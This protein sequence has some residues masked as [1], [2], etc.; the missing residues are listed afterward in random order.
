MLII[1]AELADM[2][3]NQ[4]HLEMHSRGHI[5]DFSCVISVWD[6]ILVLTVTYERALFARKSRRRPKVM[7]C[8]F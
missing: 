7:E 3:L 5:L 4:K 1:W 6:K 8:D 2:S